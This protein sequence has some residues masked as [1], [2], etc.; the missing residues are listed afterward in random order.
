MVQCP[1]TTKWLERQSALHG[2]I[3]SSVS[4]F[5]SRDIFDRKI[6]ES[7]RHSLCMIK[8]SAGNTRTNSSHWYYNISKIS[9]WNYIKS[10]VINCKYL[11]IKYSHINDNGSFW[12]SK[13]LT[14][15]IWILIRMAYVL[16]EIKHPIWMLTKMYIFFTHGIIIISVKSPT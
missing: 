10:K 5:W 11:D 4:S 9:I 1:L 8:F 2:H 6:L 15:N 3:N 13:L 16:E 7:L 12:G 14:L